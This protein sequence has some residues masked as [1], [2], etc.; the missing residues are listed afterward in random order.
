[1]PLGNPT[2]FP[3]PGSQPWTPTKSY[4]GGAG[5]VYTNP[6]GA[7]TAVPK[8]GAIPRGPGQYGFGQ[9]PFSGYSPKSKKEADEYIDPKNMTGQVLQQRIENFRRELLKSQGK[10]Q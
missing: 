8:G 5:T 10:Q 1:M 7:K 6:W 9:D 2:P 4:G 3:A